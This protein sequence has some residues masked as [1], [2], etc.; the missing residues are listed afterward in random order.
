MMDNPVGELMLLR[1]TGSVEHYTDEF[2][3][4]AY[5]DADLTKQHLV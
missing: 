3:I 4:F 5:H 1:C 2:L